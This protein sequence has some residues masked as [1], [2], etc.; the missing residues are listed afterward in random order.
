VSQLCHRGGVHRAEIAATDGRD[1]HEQL[2]IRRGRPRVVENDDGTGQ[3]GTVKDERRSSGTRNG[4]I[5]L[6][7]LAPFTWRDRTASYR[8]VTHI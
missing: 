2:R 6:T 1:P 3:E 7:M 5:A 8:N 4:S